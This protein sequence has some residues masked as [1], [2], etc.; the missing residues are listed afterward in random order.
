VSEPRWLSLEE[1]LVMHERQLARFGGAAGVR[2]RA[3][4]ES[5][6]SRPVNKWTYEKS[7]LVDLA[8]AYA[9][10][11]ARNHAFVDGN[12]RV[13]FLA[14]ATFLRLNGIHFAPAQETATAAVFGLAAGTIDEAG[15]ARWMTDNVP[16]RAGRLKSTPARP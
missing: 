8:A 14:M 4:L 6:Q 13:A 9:F 15:F 16:P 7:S 12:K 11:I 5:A 1:V 10:G 2:D 3:A